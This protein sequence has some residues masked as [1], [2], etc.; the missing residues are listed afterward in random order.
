M[1]IGGTEVIAIDFF[2][3]LAA[4]VMGMPRSPDSYRDRNRHDVGVGRADV[5]MRFCLSCFTANATTAS[6]FR[7]AVPMIV[8]T[9][10]EIPQMFAVFCK[11]QAN[12]DSWSPLPRSG[13]GRERSARN[14][15]AITLLLSSSRLHYPG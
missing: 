7:Y 13:R 5:R 2:E 1:G 11:S 8:G 9:K 10:S 14:D 3:G 6:S 4:I 12:R 15:G